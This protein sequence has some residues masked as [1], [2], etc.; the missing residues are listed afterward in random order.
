MIHQKYYTKGRHKECIEEMQDIAGTKTVFDFC[1]MNMYK[2]S[3]R[4]GLKTKN[5]MQDME[6][7]KWYREYAIRIIN[8]RHL[9]VRLI[10]SRKYQKVVKACAEV[11]NDND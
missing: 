10:Y 7:I 2:Y 9:F 11:M 6:K 4:A 8:S 1:L 3:Y 5:R